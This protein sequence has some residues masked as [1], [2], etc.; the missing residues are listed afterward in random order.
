MRKYIRNAF[1][2][3]CF[4]LTVFSAS[5]IHAAPLREQPV[6]IE[7]PDGE[8]INC[9]ASGD[10]FFSYLTD[11]NG[12]IILLDET[13]GY[14]KYAVIDE[15]GMLVPGEHVV[16]ENVSG[17]GSQGG[18]ASSFVTSETIPESYIDSVKSENSIL[19]SKQNGSAMLMS[20]AETDPYNPSKYQNKTIH[21][22]VIF[23]RFSNSNFS[24]R[25]FSTY[26]KVFNTDTKS[27]KNYYN[28]VS[29]GKVQIESEFCPAPSASTIITY[30]AP[31][32]RSYYI[33][34]GS[35]RQAKEYSLL[36]GAL[37]WA[38]NNNY[39]PEDVDLD[40]N[41]DGDVDAVT[42][43]VSGN[44]D[45]SSNAIF[46]P[47]QWNFWAIASGNDEIPT[48][49]GL[50]FSKFTLNTEGVL[51]GN[52]TGNPY[53]TY[54]ASLC[55]ETF[56][57]VF[58]GP[59]LY[60]GYRTPNINNGAVGDWDIMCS[61][62]GGH[63]DT[64]LKYRYGQWINIPEITEEGR[65]TLNP[66]TDDENNCYLI[67][68]PYSANEYFVLEYR[69]K[70]NRGTFEYN[71]PD[72]G[73]VIY[74]INDFYRGNYDSGYIY[75][76]GTEEEKEEVYVYRVNPSTSKTST[77]VNSASYVD[78]RTDIVLKLR[79]S[80]NI[81]K[82]TPVVNGDN[83]GITISNVSAAS[84]TISFDVSFTEELQYGFRDIRVAEA[85][86]A[87]AGKTP[88]TL[89]QA[90]YESI[91]S[92]SLPYSSWYE[93]PYDLTGIERCVN[94]T[95]F[96]ANDRGITDITPLA[97]LTKLTELELQDN[98]ITDIT[99]L[100]GLTA[101][102]TLKLRGNLIT[103]YTPTQTYYSSLTT[104][105]FS[106]SN[107][108]DVILRNSA[109]DYNTGIPSITADLS[110][111]K[112]ARIYVNYELYN[113]DNEKIAETQE[114]VPLSGTTKE[115]LSVPEGYNCNNG[116]YLRVTAYERED[117]RQQL[118]TIVIK[119][120]IFDFSIN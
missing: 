49:N 44:V 85:V 88:A 79:K 33:N 72:S 17:G 64:Y 4:V 51:T 24:T 38:I 22:I 96:T 40:V 101:L 21:N 102:K 61:S 106:L 90:D 113:S 27:L 118:Y 108:G 13:T 109:Y 42:F 54:A 50:V 68:S 83:A 36:K 23:I 71:I 74:R 77:D 66:I 107:T 89:T 87:A 43:I 110:A 94:L 91:T 111:T 47:H 39:I 104:K 16:S 62:N 53:Q 116:N 119:P 10:E 28:E 76:S 70:G 114:R 31:N 41:D 86:A 103:D 99:A 98:N 11:E 117:Y 73:L 100:S 84:D 25:T 56:H 19:A 69:K 120:S 55:H 63:M 29:Y 52:T 32:P 3:I 95:S 58:N 26:D 35:N 57:M 82:T 12:S 45:T 37:Q 105:D 115:V 60:Y 97:S 80:G 14:Y 92:L 5:A 67:R 15:A 18:A 6:V 20:A 59:D 9:F 93:L 46:W 75:D 1:M 112:P 2:L 81:N 78:R 7:Q 34:P 48:F 65:Y 8:V 30:T